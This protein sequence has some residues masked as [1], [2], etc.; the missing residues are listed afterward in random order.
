MPP[1]NT[2]SENGG[3][4]L[5]LVLYKAGDMRLEQ[6]PL[7]SK[8]AR[9]EVLLQTQQVGICGSD[10]SYW[11]KGHIGGF[12]VKD[13]M[14]LGHE[15]SAKVVEVG[16]GVTHLKPGDRVAIEPGVPCRYCVDCKEG[17]YNLCSGIFFSATPPDNGTLTR[18]FKHAADYCFKLPDH[19]S[20]AEGALMEPLSVAIHACSRANVSG[21]QKILI[22]GAGPIGLM[23][24]LVAKAYGATDICITDINAERL[25][26]AK[27]IGAT[28]TFLLSKDLG[29]NETAEA[30]EKLMGCRPE[31]V[32]ECS[33]ASPSIRLALIVC[34]SGGCVVLIGMGADEVQVPLLSAVCR[35]VDIRGVFRY[36]NSYPKAVNLISSG[37][38]DVKPI[39]SH[40]FKLEQAHDA[41]ELARS[42]KAV[43][44]I[45]D[46]SLD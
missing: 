10:V 31:A 8:P 19:V 9:N 38:I 11:V 3:D 25:A 7:P 15:T 1:N 26:L 12:W 46:C 2:V 45:I 27:K 18:Y 29:E 5:S 13:P 44:I 23:C 40:Y 36:K 28:S 22:L 42:G 21:G 30:I 37:K 35:E 4:N 43:K 39:I 24:I 32:L 16:E 20:Y 33:G 41:F 14:I 34:K 17:A 6:T